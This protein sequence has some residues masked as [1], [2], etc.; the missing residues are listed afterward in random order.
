MDT[1][2]VQYPKIQIDGEAHEVKFTCGDIIALSKQGVDL[3]KISGDSLG[4]TME[5]AFKLLS[6]AISRSV[7]FTPEA[8]AEK[9]DLREFAQVSN[10]LT[11]AISKAT[12]QANTIQLKEPAI[13]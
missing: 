6:V 11:A 1:D 7:K 10:A 2:P 9:F 5:N 12:A 13:Q 3:A 4:V 8:L